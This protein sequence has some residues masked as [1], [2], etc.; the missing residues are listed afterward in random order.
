MQVRQTLKGKIIQDALL[1]HS[2]VP[3]PEFLYPRTTT[4]TS[5]EPGWSPRL[6]FWIQGNVLA[7]GILQESKPRIIILYMTHLKKVS[8]QQE[9][10]KVYSKR[11]MKYMHKKMV[12][13]CLLKNKHE[14]ATSFF[15]RWKW[16]YQIHWAV[17]SMK[18]LHPFNKKF[19]AMHKTTHCKT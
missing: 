1:I 12:Q 15:K 5:P 17:N 13:Q 19:L 7:Y 11:L 4:L 16:S 8:L 18:K 10:S 6:V 14:K 3:G 2:T 9:Q